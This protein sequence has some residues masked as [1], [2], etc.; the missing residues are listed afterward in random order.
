MK[1]AEIIID[2][3]SIWWQQKLRLGIKPTWLC[4]FAIALSLTFVINACSLGQNQSLKPLRVGITSWVGFDIARYAE[5]SGIFKQRGLKVE[6]VR[7]EN[8]QDS[9]RAVM[10][11][12]WIVGQAIANQKV[13]GY[14]GDR[15]KILVIDDREENRLVA[16]NMLEP[17]GFKVA[18]AADG[19]TGLDLAIQMRPDLI[20]TDVHMSIMDGLEMTRRL[21][22]L[23]DFA[24]TPIIASPATL[25]QVDM[26]SSLDAGCSSFF[27]K[28][29]DFTGLLAELQ[30]H[31]ELQWIYETAP[32][33]TQPAVSN[34]DEVA[35][36]MVMMPPAAELAALY[37][38]AQGGFIS[39]IQQEA[40]R[41]KQLSSEYTAFANRVLE[42][43][44]QFDDE[45]ILRLIEPQC[46]KP[47]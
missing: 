3:F 23:P 7:F 41:L 30:R 37:T 6:L 20:I 18:E 14:Q 17:L 44:Q 29:L 42:L 39:D 21:R 45:A 28:P 33:A 9:S 11:S 34:V 40:N 36:M 25:S 10:R 12:D 46:L 38:A 5:P 31:L 27:P 43:S 15:R 47:L 4:L 35:L 13:V 26:Q 19:Q 8:Q 16:V 1:I 24:T 2:T 22:Q 32:E